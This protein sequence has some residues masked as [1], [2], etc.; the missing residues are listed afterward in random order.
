LSRQNHHTK[1]I[2][3]IV[4]CTTLCRNW[5]S[6]WGKFTLF[7]IT[8]LLVF[9]YVVLTTRQCGSLIIDYAYWLTLSF[10]GPLD[11][12]R[13]FVCIGVISSSCSADTERRHDNELQRAVEL[14][15]RK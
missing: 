1:D 13:L 7:S 2:I 6:R 10:E 8:L 5:L 4:R 14:D 12:L 3:Q 11:C 15:D 9:C